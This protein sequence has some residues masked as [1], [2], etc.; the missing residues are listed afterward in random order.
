M[1]TL[2]TSVVL[3]CLASSAASAALPWP[4]DMKVEKVATAADAI[5]VTTTGGVFEFRPAAG[6]VLLRQRIGKQR[7]VGVLRLEP[8]LLAG[9]KVVKKDD[10]AVTLHSPGGLDA[11]V[12][13]DSV[14]RLDR[15]HA[16]L[17][18]TAV[19]SFAPE[20]LRAERPGVLALDNVGGF[21]VYP[22]PQVAKRPAVQQSEKGFT[23]REEMP[24]GGT[25]LV[26]R[27]PAP[28]VQL[29]AARR[30]ADRASVPATPAGRVGQ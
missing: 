5:T 2:L 3:F 11:T 27:L 15:D 14:L 30:G 16:P 28:A 17:A 18:A 22:L 12:T 1:R 9:L 23:F 4:F 10:D 21:G 7:D 19:G 8:A 6:E 29:E 13:C 24:E 26:L 25:L 20:F